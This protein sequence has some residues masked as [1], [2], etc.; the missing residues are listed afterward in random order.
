V[1]D[2]QV[3]ELKRKPIVFFVDDEEGIRPIISCARAAST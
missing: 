1:S 3:E 2:E